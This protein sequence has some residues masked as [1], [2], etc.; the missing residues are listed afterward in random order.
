MDTIDILVSFVK[1]LFALII[2]AISDPVSYL[3]LLAFCVSMYMYINSDKLPILK[4]ISS[5]VA[6]GRVR[7]KKNSE[8]VEEDNGE[9]TDQISN[10][11]SGPSR[12]T[13]Q[14]QFASPEYKTNYMKFKA[15]LTIDNMLEFQNNYG[16]IPYSLLPD[17]GRGNYRNKLSTAQLA[18][19]KV[20]FELAYEHYGH[21]WPS[22]TPPYDPTLNIKDNGFFYTCRCCGSE[23]I[24]PE[25][26]VADGYIYCDYSCRFRAKEIYGRIGA[27]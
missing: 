20:M 15:L 1:I 17:P 4:Y 8:N 23:L 24:E 10:F 12:P 27:W 9:K 7:L 16:Y 21:T 6:W 3:L 2:Y 26:Y 14:E 13:E 22:H 11:E 5:R 25:K 19:L 18:E